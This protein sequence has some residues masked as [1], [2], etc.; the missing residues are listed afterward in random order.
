[1]DGIP[2]FKPPWGRVTAIDMSTGEHVWQV[3]NGRGPRDHPALAD[4][5]LGN[6]GV[7]GESFPLLTSTLLFTTVDRQGSQPAMLNA[8]DKSTGE[9]LLEFEL[10]GGVH[11]NPMTYM[12]EGKQY[13]VVSVNAGQ[14]GDGVVALALE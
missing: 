7:D 1:V 13:L 14:D 2:I 8:Y 4:L 11:A 12:Y 5:D 6:L 9:M 10:P 3:A